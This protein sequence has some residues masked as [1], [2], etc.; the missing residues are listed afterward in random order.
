MTGGEGVLTAI[1]MK[2]L[3]RVPVLGSFR[4]FLKIKGRPFMMM[5]GANNRTTFLVFIEDVNAVE[6]GTANFDSCDSKRD[7]VFCSIYD[8]AGLI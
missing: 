2:H 7:H 3:V 4:P 5:A 6:K 8:A 1:L